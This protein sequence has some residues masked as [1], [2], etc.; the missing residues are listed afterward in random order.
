ME[1]PSGFATYRYIE[2]GSAVYIV[3]LYVV[4][5]CR[6]SGHAAG[7]ADLIAEIARGRGCKSMVGTV[8]PSTKGSTDSLKV[9]IAYGMTLES[10]EKNVII[11]RKGL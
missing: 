11:F 5:E 6:K 9:L 10:S 8:V 1:S 4:P 2:D 7:M 3:D